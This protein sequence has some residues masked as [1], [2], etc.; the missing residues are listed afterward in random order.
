MVHD[1]HPA[2]RALIKSRPCAHL[3]T[4]RPNGRPHVSFIW[5]DVTDE[6]QIQFGTPPWRVK[7]KNLAQDPNCI[8]SIQDN[9]KGDNGL[10]R[11]LLIDGVASIDH[12]LERG[13][14][15]MDQLFYEYTGSPVFG[16]SEPG[17]VLV[18]V[19]IT[20]VSGVGPWHTGKTTSYGTPI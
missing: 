7:G 10:L 19:D 8:L 13:Q 18:T 9:Q 14:R 1:L 2:A 16:L 20:R 15:F 4:I 5:L 3:V 6:G 12:D 11:H 17:H